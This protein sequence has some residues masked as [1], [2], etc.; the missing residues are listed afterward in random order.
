V[1]GE[2]LA[3]YRIVQLLGEGGMGVVYLAE[4]E[5]LRRPAAIKMLHAE[6][7]RSPELVQ[8][9]MA[10]ARA[11]AAIKHPGIV[12]VLDC[13]VHESG[14]AYIVMELLEGSSLGR[15]LHQRGVMEPAEIAVVGQQ[16]AAAVGAA[17]E[18]GLVHRDLKPENVFLVGGRIDQVKVLD[19]GIAKLM[20]DTPG[21]PRTRT[22]TVL[23]TPAYMSPEQCRGTGEVDHRSDLYSLGCVLYEMACGRLPFAYLGTGELMAA[24]LK[25]PPPPPRSWNA[26][27]PPAL[28][29]LV[30]RLLS[31]APG[32]R[33]RSMA[34]LFDELSALSAAPVE[35]PLGARTQRLEPTAPPAAT[36]KLEPTAVLPPAAEEP[37]PPD[38]TLAAAAAEVEPAP[39][40]P[41]RVNLLMLPIQI[42]GPAIGLFMLVRSFGGPVRDYVTGLFRPASVTPPAHTPTPTPPVELPKPARPVRP[43]RRATGPLP[44]AHHPFNWG[45]LANPRDDATIQW[46]N[47]ILVCLNGVS[48]TAMESFQHYQSWVKDLD[49][50]PTGKEM[51]S[52]L[53]RLGSMKSC[54]LRLHAPA[55]GVPGDALDAAAAYERTMLV[56]ARALDE[57]V[58]HY[59][60]G[61]R[62]AAVE[63]R[64]HRPLM[65]AFRDF[66]D[67]D[68]ALRRIFQAH[69]KL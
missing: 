33:P 24:H 36:M 15:V 62:D 57:T 21:S 54:S 23:G 61:E 13:G 59:E 32:D 46:L 43:S 10:E 20:G 50:G 1:I 30:M 35:T 11:T 66:S 65:A 60:A 4:H 41:S 7:S 28:E 9:F 56:L 6:L 42:I 63:R 45:A 8:R 38:T 51:G 22:G 37:R 49:A 3:N 34:A 67:A 29:A 68:A 16:I 5:L 64:L 47:E 53:F 55:T 58:A 26:A 18:H 44:F 12:E 17:H 48:L 19:F 27:V 31:K 40:K 52:G 14:K 25:E 39:P 69:A 2:R